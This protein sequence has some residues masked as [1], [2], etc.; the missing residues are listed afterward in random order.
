MLLP[1]F[2][3]FCFYQNDKSSESKVK[4]RQASNYCKRILEDAKLAY[5]NKTRVHHFPETWVSGLL[6]LANGVFDKGK[7]A[8]PPLFND[9]EVLS[10]ASDEAKFLLK[11]FLRTLILMTLD[12]FTCFP[13]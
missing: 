5:I 2:F 1:S 13:F 8:I 3:F 6:Q 11:T 12:L 4:F 7:S 9:P 10:S